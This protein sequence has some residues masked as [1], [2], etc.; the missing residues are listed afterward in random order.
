NYFKRLKDLVTQ[1]GKRGIFIEL[2]LFGNQYK[3]SLWMNSPLYPSNNIQQV[4]PS[5][6]NSFLL[7]QTLKDPELVKR[8]EAFVYKIVNELNSFDNLYYEIC[9]EPYN[10]QKDSS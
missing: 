10:E 9:N 3:D 5:G 1:A 8:Q 2:T 7:F 6:K 4:G